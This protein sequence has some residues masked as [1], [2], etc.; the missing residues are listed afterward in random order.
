MMYRGSR[1]WRLI[2][3]LAAKV[4]LFAVPSA[5]LVARLGRICTI[6]SLAIKK[7]SKN[8]RCRT[9]FL[10]SKDGPV[11]APCESP[12]F[13]GFVWQFCAVQ[14]VTQTEILISGSA[15]IFLVLLIPIMNFAQNLGAVFP[16]SYV[17]TV[18]KRLGIK[19][20]Q[21]DPKPFIKKHTMTS[22]RWRFHLKNPI[23]WTIC[24]GHFEGRFLA[25]Y[26]RQLGWDIFL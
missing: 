17:N 20:L 5:N 25:K 3:V 21:L 8:Y 24:R 26:H 6:C 12:L 4:S 13:A 18:R 15:M 19:F 23:R 16:I 9:T 1:E 14:G 2:L 11:E 22:S 7:L 10:T